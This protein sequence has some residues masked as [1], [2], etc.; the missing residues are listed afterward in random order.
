MN[1]FKRILLA[2]MAIP[3]V[4]SGCSQFD[5]EVSLR[6]LSFEIG[7]DIVWNAEYMAY[8]LRLSLKE[9]SDGDYLFSYS[10]DGDA[11]IKLLSTGGGTVESGRE[12]SLEGSKPAIYILPGLASDKEHTLSM[13]FTKDGVSRSYNVKLPDTSQNGIGIRIDTDEALDFSRVIL[14]NL[15]GPSV[16]TYNVT[17]YLDGEL[18]TGIKYMS[19][20]FEGT[21]DVDFARSESYTFE[22]P[23]LVAG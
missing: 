1:T 19:N 11:L 4:L 17:F 6:E 5:S 2:F 13:E 16:T 9:G 3:A 23:Y 15:M 12:L 10:I 22:M 21:M 7:S 20:T 8:T 14:T 18:L